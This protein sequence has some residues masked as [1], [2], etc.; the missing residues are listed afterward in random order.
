MT[1]SQCLTKPPSIERLDGS[2]SIQALQLAL[3][4]QEYAP[5]HPV[6]STNPMKS[7]PIV[8][9]AELNAGD[10]DISSDKVTVG[11]ATSVRV[12]HGDVD[13]RFK[14]E[15]QF[16]RRLRL[17]RCRVLH[18]STPQQESD[19]IKSVKCCRRVLIKLLWKT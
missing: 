10:Q 12:F 7:A 11:D 17:R 3:L 9:L 8:E 18:R 13:S 1:A 15:S 5:T 4:Q 16:R 2:I 6:F 19:I 14:G